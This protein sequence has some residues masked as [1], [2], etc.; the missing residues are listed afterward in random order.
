MNKWTRKEIKILKD[1]YQIKSQ[2]DLMILLPDRTRNSIRLKAFSLKLCYQCGTPEKRFWKH[3]DKKENNECWDWIGACN[4][5]GYGQIR[6]NDKVIRVH[7]FSWIIHN[8]KIP[9]DLYVLH[10]CDNPLCVNPNHLFLGTHQDN[11]DDMINKKRDNKAKGENHGMAKLTSK[12]VKKIKVLLNQKEISRKRISKMFNI[13]Q[14]VIA[15]IN[16]DKT[17]RHVK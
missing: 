13:S 12:E 6:L 5:Y 8:G 1:N 15:S 10:K 16:T 4:K 11:M 17:W 14:S 9:G 2:K 3:I 7:R